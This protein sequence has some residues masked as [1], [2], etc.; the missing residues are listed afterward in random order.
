M[1]NFSK[2]ENIYWCRANPGKSNPMKLKRKAISPAGNVTDISLANGKASVQL[3]G[4]SYAQMIQ[5]EK[6]H[7]RGWVWYEECATCEPA[8]AVEDRT[9]EEEWCQTCRAREALIDTRQQMRT[10]SNDEYL[11]LF[12]SKLDKVAKLLEDKA[13]DSVRPKISEQ[14]LAKAL[15]PVETKKRRKA[16]SEVVG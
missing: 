6:E 13:I 8:P 5:H 15:A 2:A 10:K 3:I 16:K 1:A 4:N 11:V 9:G 14:D 7:R 12:E